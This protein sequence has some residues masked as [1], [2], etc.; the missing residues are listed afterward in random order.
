MR[1]DKIPAEYLAIDGSAV[2]ALPSIAYLK[3]GTSGKCYVIPP[4]EWT[5]G[6]KDDDMSDY[7]EDLMIDIRVE[8]DDRSMSRYH[9]DIILRENIIGEYSL[10]IRDS[11]RRKNATYVDG[12]R[13]SNSFEFQLFDNSSIQIGNTCFAVWLNPVATESPKRSK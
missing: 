6:R 4:G 9:A 1:T 8:T 5:L 13:I 10:F 2:E 3:D 11:S 7:P 12:Y